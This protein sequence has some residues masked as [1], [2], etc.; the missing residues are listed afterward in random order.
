MKIL[1]ALAVVTV[2]T[3][4]SIYS[5][6]ERDL[7]SHEHG[8]ATLNVALDGDAV[9]IELETPWNNLV[10]FEHTPG[11]AGQQALVDE[12]LVL[13]NRPDQL[14]SFN[15]ADC[16]VTETLLESG[17]TDSD[18]DHHEDEDHGDKHG[19]KHDEGHDEDHGDEHAE[20]HGDERDDDHDD[21]HGDDHKVHGDEE[22]S[23]ASILATYSFNCSN[24]DKLDAIEVELL[25]IWSGF[26]DLDVQLIGPGGQAAQELSAQQ[27]RLDVTPIR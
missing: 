11:T 25:N 17:L 7:G 4:T 23:H 13:L 12:A 3:S 22:E 26:E 16:D 27:T 15:G 5:Q 6:T 18:D 24:I 8:S 19:E 1:T 2:C 10:G 9:F 21:E 14:F 20:K